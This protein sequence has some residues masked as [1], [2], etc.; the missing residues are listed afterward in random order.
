[1]TRLSAQQKMLLALEERLFLSLD[2]TANPSIPS[3]ATDKSKAAVNRSDI[4]SKGKRARSSLESANFDGMREITDDYRVD[5]VELPQLSSFTALGPA[6][7]KSSED[8]LRDQSKASLKFSQD[9]FHVMI[10]THQEIRNKHAI[11]DLSPAAVV[12][13]DPDLLAIRLLETH[14]A[15]TKN[16]IKVSRNMCICA[17][18]YKILY[19]YICISYFDVYRKVYF[20]VYDE[21]IEQHRYNGVIAREKKAFESL[22]SNKA[23]MVIPTD[24]IHP[25]ANEE[26]NGAR[27][28][29]N[30]YGLGETDSRVS[31]SLNAPGSSSASLFGLQGAQQSVGVIVDV[32]EFRSSLPFLLYS[33]GLKLIPVT[34]I[35]SQ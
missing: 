27:P 35:V 25:K 28:L 26:A 8:P 2:D 21:S 29:P 12:L 14:A 9:Q 7:K 30:P 33:A 34:L 4:F 17:Y 13:L 18:I 20:V 31:D 11:I 6:Q 5:I 23:H 10:L 1:M 19:K 16:V 32:R 3:E 22:I 15:T 24:V